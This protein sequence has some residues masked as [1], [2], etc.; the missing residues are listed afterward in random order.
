MISTTFYLFIHKKYYEEPNEE[1]DN[2]PR[3]SYILDWMARAIPLWS[4]N[5]SRS[6]N[7][8]RKILC[9]DPSKEFLARRISQRVET[10][11]DQERQC[12]GRSKLGG[13]RERSI[14]EEIGAG[15]EK[16]HAEGP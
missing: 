5:L 12:D 16:D 14:Y 9:G 11:K 10:R 2:F 4:A 13:G 15:R 1:R 6:F 8:M 7:V 3:G